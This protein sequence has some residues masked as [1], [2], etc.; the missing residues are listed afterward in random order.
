MEVCG[1]QVPIRCDEA[2]VRPAGSEVNRLV[3]DNSRI[4]ALTDWRPATPFR[5]GLALTA[6][7][8]GRN[9]AAF[10]PG[11]YAV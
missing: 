10:E 11:R 1:R 7:W 6:E 5:E 2:R 3:A 8:I 9:L 4:T